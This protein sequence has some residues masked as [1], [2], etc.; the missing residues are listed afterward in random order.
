MERANSESLLSP[1]LIAALTTGAILVAAL[2]VDRL[3]QQRFDRVR[4]AR[5]LRSL[6]NVRARLE[7][8]L[9]QR[10]FLT[11]GLRAYVSTPSEY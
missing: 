6:S 8:E 11:R 2:A 10:L 4:E 3:E 7:A 9:N 1:Y 5:I